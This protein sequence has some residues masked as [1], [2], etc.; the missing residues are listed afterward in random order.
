LSLQEMSKNKETRA[1]AIPN[2]LLRN[3][4]D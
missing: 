3:F 4:A 1:R 2:Y